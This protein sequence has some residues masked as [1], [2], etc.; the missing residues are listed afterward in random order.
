MTSVVTPAKV[1]LARNP[2]RVIGSMAF[3]AGNYTTGGLAADLAAL[4]GIVN[5]QPTIVNFTSKAGYLYYYDAS[6]GKVRVNTTANT[7]H[8]AAALAA[9]VVSDVVR[10]EAVYAS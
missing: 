4:T 5:R 2:L 3:A 1:A 9:S 8:A 7:E 10:F 6:T